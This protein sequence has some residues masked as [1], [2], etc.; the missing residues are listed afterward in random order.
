MG[1]DGD[2]RGNDTELDEL[3]HIM[4]HDLQE[5]LRMITSY[6]QLLEKKYNDKLDSDAKEY[7]GYAIEGANRLKVM[8]NDLLIYSNV[9]HPKL[10]L[11][12]VAL[13]DIA[14]EV[15]NQLNAKYSE[16]NYQLKLD[17][18]EAPQ[19]NADKALMIKLI[20][21]IIDNGLKFNHTEKPV[22]EIKS[23]ANNEE[24][25]LSVK[26]NG[27]GIDKEYQERI[28]GIFQKLHNHKEYPGTG[29]GLAICQKIANKHNGKIW[30]DSDTGNGAT[31]HISIPMIQT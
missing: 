7:I 23:R 11:K 27:V 17:F 26:D 22:I 16:N 8:M 12:Q 31:F 6:V 15:K 1:R 21:N 20:Y 14:E 10:N 3:R 2:Q 9:G 5:P 13:E 29:I 25:L 28:F 30:V 19:V 4:T 24:F 18:A